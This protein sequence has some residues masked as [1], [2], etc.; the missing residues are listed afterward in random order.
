MKRTIGVVAL[1]AALVT[2]FAGVGV[3]SSPP[4]LLVSGYSLQGTALTVDVTN[5]G[6]TTASGVLDVRVVSNG[7][8]VETL[9]YPFSVGG[10][11][12][13]IILGTI[14]DDLNPLEYLT[15]GLR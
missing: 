4:Q 1:L 9:S 2:V 3:Q 14:T 8:V 11:D 13:I 6:P 10:L 12:S 15:F 7:V 5:T